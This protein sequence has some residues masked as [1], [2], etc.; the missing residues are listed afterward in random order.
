MSYNAVPHFRTFEFVLEPAGAPM[1]TREIHTAAEQLSGEPLRWSSVK[2][3]L[4]AH[5]EGSK[6][7]FERVRRGYYRIRKPVVPLSG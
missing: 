5:A 1:R 2:G 3:T 7:R 4:A 6:P